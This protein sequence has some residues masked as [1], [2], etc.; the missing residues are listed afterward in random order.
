MIES[1]AS[2]KTGTGFRVETLAPNHTLGPVASWELSA[3]KD[4]RDLGGD[5]LGALPLGGLQE[6][7]SAPFFCYKNESSCSSS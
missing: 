1:M 5:G 2:G 7:G 6:Q 3:C 4:V